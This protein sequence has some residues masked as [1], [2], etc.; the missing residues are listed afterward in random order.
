M[1]TSAQPSAPRRFEEAD[2]SALP[3][4]VRDCVE[5][6]RATRRG[7][8]LWGPVGSGKTYAI[9]AIKKRL[10]EMGIRVRIYSAP[11][12]FDKIRDDF[13]HKDSYN[14]ERILANR[15]VLIIDDLGAEKPSEWVSE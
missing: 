1:T 2:Y 15:G 10:E 7:I 12:M 3:Q 13:D 4:R 11:E 6:V 8:Y 5:N 14:L 9:Y